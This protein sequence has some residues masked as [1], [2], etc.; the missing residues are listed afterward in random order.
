MTYVNVVKDCLDNGIT[1]KH[2]IYARL[3]EAFPIADTV[4]YEIRQKHLNKLW[5]KITPAITYIRA[6]EVKIN[7]SLINKYHVKLVGSPL[8]QLQQNLLEQ[9]L[10]IVKEKTNLRLPDIL[11]WSN[12][13]RRSCAQRHFYKGFI[14]KL[15]K[16]TMDNELFGTLLHEL[17]HVNGFW[18]HKDSFFNKLIEVGIMCGL[19]LDNWFLREYP[20]GRRYYKVYKENTGLR[21]E[22]DDTGKI[23]FSYSK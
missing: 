15:S 19:D 10:R 23:I 7:T 1:S 4:P 5:K 21:Q 8:S 2:S 22:L 17:V 20:H 12:S 3:R 11:N 14:I 16:H 18:H 6:K 13:R 9:Y